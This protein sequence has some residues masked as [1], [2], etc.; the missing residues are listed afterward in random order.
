M[1]L[2]MA[3]E[4]LWSQSVPFSVL[5]RQRVCMAHNSPTFTG[6]SICVC[7]EWWMLF[8]SVSLRVLSP[9]G[10]SFYRGRWQDPMIGKRTEGGSCMCRGMKRMGSVCRSILRHHKATHSTQA[11]EPPVPPTVAPLWLLICISLAIGDVECFFT[12]LSAFHMLSFEKCL[13]RSF[14]HF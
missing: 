2:E 5:L 1:C 8:C 12:Q 7:W 14:A 10:Q 6:T 13:F 9:W 3:V 11:V 4:T